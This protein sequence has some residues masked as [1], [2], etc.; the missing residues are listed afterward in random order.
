VALSDFWCYSIALLRH[1]ENDLTDDSEAV[2]IPFACKEK[3]PNVEEMQLFL[4]IICV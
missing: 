2:A 4:D 3:F 1:P